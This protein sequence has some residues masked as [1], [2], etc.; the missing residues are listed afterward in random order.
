MKLKY[1]LRGLGIGIV[2]TA[3]ILGIAHTA[4]EKKQGM[5]DEE[6]IARAKELGMTESMVLADMLPSSEESTEQSAEPES[7][8]EEN[9]EPE[10]TVAENNEPESS[11]EEN[12][13]PESDQVKEDPEK[14]SIE[15]SSEPESTP[16]GEQ[17]MVEIHIVS[18]DSSV[19]VSQKL[20][21]AGLVE[22]VKEYDRYLCA[23]G[24]D[25][26]IRVG[27]YTISVS[28]TLEEIAK[29]ITGQK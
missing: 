1:Y 24:Y 6:V 22:D 18:G 16:S 7:T 11:V 12:I 13:E 2:V 5:T 14:N 3:L 27:T 17:E 21:D 25:K 29:I 26:K 28:A 20:A 8:D 19:S 4:Q 10:S 15:E 23:N 9:R